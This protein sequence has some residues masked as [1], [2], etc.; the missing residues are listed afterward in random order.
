MGNTSIVSSMPTRV[1]AGAG[2]VGIGEIAR[3]GWGRVRRRT[4]GE[5]ERG[6]GS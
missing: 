5:D 6:V 1:T 4:F 3:V 2:E